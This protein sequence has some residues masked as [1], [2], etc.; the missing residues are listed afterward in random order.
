MIILKNTTNQDQYLQLTNGLLFTKEKIHESIVIGRLQAKKVKLHTLHIPAPLEK[1][2]K[3]VH[4]KNTE[5]SSST[6]KKCCSC[7]VP[8]HVNCFDGY[9]KDKMMEISKNKVDTNLT[10]KKDVE[11]NNKRK[12]TVLYPS[13]TPIRPNSV[14]EEQPIEDIIDNHYLPTFQNS[15]NMLNILVVNTDNSETLLPVAPDQRLK[16]MFE[17]YKE[18]KQL[19]QAS[20]YFENTFGSKNC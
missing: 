12:A 6:T 8:L 10:P 5:I 16:G 1:T 11:K 20:F 14:V 2:Q 9:H 4:C 17:Y 19:Q 13:V 15:P 18:Q 7:D 3:C